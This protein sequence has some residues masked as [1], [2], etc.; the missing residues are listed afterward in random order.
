M[1]KMHNVEFLEIAACR[2]S[3]LQILCVECRSHLLLPHPEIF[4]HQ[5]P[6]NTASGGRMWKFCSLQFVVDKAWHFML[7]RIPEASP[8]RRIFFLPLSS[9]FCNVRFRP[10]SILSLNTPAFRLRLRYR[11][12]TFTIRNFLFRANFWNQNGCSATPTKK[13][14]AK[15]NFAF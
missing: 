14:I 10:E 12:E 7:S 2:C 4:L 5:I 1:H 3:V 15:S 11:H 6:V 9:R 13:V 8:I